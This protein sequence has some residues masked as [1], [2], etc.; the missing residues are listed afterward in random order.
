MT[1]GH[2][3][4]YRWNLSDGYP[5]K[6][7]EPNGKKV[8]GLFVCGG[9]STMGYKL[10]GFDHLGG[11]EIDRPIADVYEANHHPKFLFREDVRVFLKRGD[12]PAELFG[13][14]IL[15]GSPPCSTFSTAGKRE[16]GFGQKK[17]F[18]EGQANQRLDDLFFTSLD[19]AERLKPKVVLFENVTGLVKGNARAY[20]NLICRRFD[21]VGYDLQV[22]QLNAASMGVPQKRD[23]VFFVGR[24]KD[25]RGGQNWKCGF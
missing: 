12:L 23:R 19:I 2:K 24:R 6:G 17:V 7:I 8:F 15:D 14:D 20:F 22:F 9:G 4:P 11:V 16:K 25:L 13:L 5:A 18:R 10:A 1:E 21:E 3:F